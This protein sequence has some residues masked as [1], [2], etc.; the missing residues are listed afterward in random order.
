MKEKNYFLQGIKIT[1]TLIDDIIFLFESRSKSTYFTRIGSNI[2]T[3]KSILIFILNFVKRSL[4]IEL[5]DFFTNVDRTD[6]YVT[7][8]AF[9][10]AM[11]KI[12]PV[13]F[14]KMS[15]EI[16]KWFYRDTDFKKYRGYRLLSIDGSVLEI[17]NTEKFCC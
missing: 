15:D 16:I 11:G 7:K 2:M 9:S 8:Q 14:I 4:Q 3:F 1:N 6:S 10:K 5:D 17:N 12:Q 13:A